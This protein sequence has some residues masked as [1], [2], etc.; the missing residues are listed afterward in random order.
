MEALTQT[1]SQLFKQG[2]LT[3]V[4]EATHRHL[5]CVCFH[6]SFPHLC[7][8]R[9]YNNMLTSLKTTSSPTSLL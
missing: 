6:N 4:G 1:P 3:N 8:Y 2:D 9:C 5:E 7:Y